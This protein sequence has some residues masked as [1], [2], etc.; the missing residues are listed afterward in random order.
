MTTD[1]D[2]CNRALDE[3]GA[4]V[5]IASLGEATPQA[6]ACTRQYT[7]L[8][9]QI[10]RSAQWGF[11]RK[12]LI[13]VPTGLLS[14]NPPTSPYPWAAKYAYPA[15]CLKVR[16]ILPTPTA[17]GGGGIAPNV[18]SLTPND[19]MMPSRRNRFLPAYDDAV[20]PATKV[21]L[22]NVVNINIIYTVDVVDP[23]LWDSLFTNAMVM[24]L[25]NKLVMTLSGNVKLKG[26]Y[27][28]L[29]QQS[30]LDARVADGN[31]AIASSDHTPD[32]IATRGIGQLMLPNFDFNL[33]SWWG[34][35]E[36]IAWGE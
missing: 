10:L 15:D 19:W 2:I 28:Q 34:A 7:A 30:I 9:Q 17:N 27:A 6:K 33:G 1:V 11:A 14:A 13:A 3:M 35:D 12:S 21:L 29:A 23:D 4:R 8:R 20:L 18:S 22:S 5:I 25:A 16:Y 32:W 36:D 31:E 26:T 24:G